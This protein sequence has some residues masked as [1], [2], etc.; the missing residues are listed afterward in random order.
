MTS[1][2]ITPEVNELL[3]S[4]QVDL[5]EVEVT[6]EPQTGVNVSII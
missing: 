3:H 1:N 2:Y 5:M 6:G 4:M